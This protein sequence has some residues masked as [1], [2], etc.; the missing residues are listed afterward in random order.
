MSVDDSLSASGVSSSSSSSTSYLA[1]SAT[2]GYR[3]KERPIDS[4]P[5]TTQIEAEEQIRAEVTKRV[6]QIMEVQDEP[7]MHFGLDV[8]LS[9]CLSAGSARNDAWS[10]LELLLEF[11]SSYLSS[12]HCLNHLILTRFLIHAHTNSVQ[13]R[14]GPRLSQVLVAI[15]KQSERIEQRFEVLRDT[16][17][18]NGGGQTPKDASATKQNSSLPCKRIGW[19][20]CMVRSDLEDFFRYS[21][22]LTQSRLRMTRFLSKLR[23]LPWTHEKEILSDFTSHSILPS[24]DLTEPPNFN[25]PRP[26]DLLPHNLTRVE[27]IDAENRRIRGVWMREAEEQQE[28]QHTTNSLNPFV[29]AYVSFEGVPSDSSPVGGSVW[30]A[31]TEPNEHLRT[32]RT[33]ATPSIF[34]MMSRTFT[35]VFHAQTNRLA[36]SQWSDYTDLLDEADSTD[37]STLAHEYESM[38]EQE[39]A[40]QKLLRSRRELEL[41]R[42]ELNRQKEEAQAKSHADRTHSTHHSSAQHAQTQTQKYILTDTT[43][44][45]IS[46]T[47]KIW[48]GKSL[49]NFRIKDK[50]EV[51]HVLSAVERAQGGDEPN[52]SASGGNSNAPAGSPLIAREDDATR[53]PPQPFNSF[54]FSTQKRDDQFS[55]PRQLIGQNGI[56]VSTHGGGSEKMTDGPKVY[57]RKATSVERKQT[58]ANQRGH[59]LAAC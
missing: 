9:E 44:P 8:F 49:N 31:M 43:H 27:E 18:E 17:R 51:D 25:Q 48:G 47:G 53:I 37:A 32:L 36:R 40:H 2:G 14:Y 12:L 58:D 56:G 6:E 55:D 3:E 21:I 1:A 15:Q 33:K 23:L 39:I 46:S 45:I 10:T 57:V 30:S 59:I 5:L 35:R 41:R 16:W 28:D 50:D 52:T 11:H 24:R 20:R 38:T 26:I 29:S 4:L 22:P 54:S 7:N 42:Q 13:E 34:D 19:D